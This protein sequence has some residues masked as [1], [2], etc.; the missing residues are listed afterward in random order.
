MSSLEPT[1]LAGPRSRLHGRG[2]K[3][4]ITAP[5]DT[6]RQAPAEQKSITT[7]D[8]QKVLAGKGKGEDGKEGKKGTWKDKEGE[9]KDGMQTK[10]EE[11]GK[12]REGN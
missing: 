11:E 3:K 4:L 9:E 5:A 7:L 2:A 10:F 12:K 1:H 6:G 8:E